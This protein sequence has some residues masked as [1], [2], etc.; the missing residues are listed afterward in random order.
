MNRVMDRS[1]GLHDRLEGMMQEAHLPAVF[2]YVS[3]VESGLDP[4]ATSGVGARGLWQFMAPTTRQYG[5]RVDRGG[6]VD[7][8][9]DV[10]KSTRAATQYIGNLIRKFGREQFMCALASYNRGEGAVWRAMEKIPDPMMPS[11][12]K[13]WWLVERKLLPRETSEYVPK[14]FAVRIIA[15]DPER[16]GFQRR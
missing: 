1:D 4:R 2:T 3:W 15:E 6:G 11:S 16:F 12:K 8:R 9:T 7:E 14:I 10:N 13:Y 5:L